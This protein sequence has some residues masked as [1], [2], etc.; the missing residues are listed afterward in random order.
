MALNISKFSDDLEKL[1]LQGFQLEE[2][3]ILTYIGIEKF[4]E[5]IF[6]DFKKDENAEESVNNYI[7]KLPDFNIGYQSWYSESLVVVR[8]L[9]PDRLDDFV[10]HYQKPRAR[11][12]ISFENYKMQDYLQG[13]RIT[14]GGGLEVVVDQSAG[15]PQFQQQRAILNSA[16]ARFKSSLF[17]I[18]QLVQA[19]LF[20]SE[21]EAA[22]ELLKNKFLRGAGAIAGVVLEK[23]LRQ[24]CDNHNVKIVKKNPGI[25]DLNDALKNSGVIDVPQWRHITLL[26]DYRNLCDHSKYKDPTT[27]QVT[28]LLDGTDKVIKMLA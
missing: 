18:R 4:R 25:A 1:I 13:L 11:K 7:K 27:E 28:D 8:Q 3:M 12:E 14:R 5:R 10:S 26:G 6:N 19:D 22:R 21:I 16:K 20:D 24:V 9:I 17:E 23:H 2:K 15:I